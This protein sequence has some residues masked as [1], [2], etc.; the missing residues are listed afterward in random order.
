[1]PS[2]IVS[3]WVQKKQEPDSEVR[4]LSQ[5]PDWQSR[6]PPVEDIVTLVGV[7]CAT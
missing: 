4:P 5:E 7:K 1:M 3:S 6:T 2:S